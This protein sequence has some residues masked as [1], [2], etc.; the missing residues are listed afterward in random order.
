MLIVGTLLS[1]LI[2]IGFWTARGRLKAS[3]FGFLAWDWTPARTLVLAAAYGVLAALAIGWIF[4]G[5][6]TG[7]LPSPSEVWMGI[8]FGPLAEELIFRGAVFHGV[9]SLLRRWWANSGWM[10]VLAVAGAFAASHLAKPDITSWQIVT[11]FAT[12]SLYG[13]LRLQSGSTVPPFCAHAVYNATVFAIA[14]LR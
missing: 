7:S 12:G 4:R 6:R 5:M 14:F 1:L 3:G 9:S 13:W 10:T 8:T 11:V 2:L